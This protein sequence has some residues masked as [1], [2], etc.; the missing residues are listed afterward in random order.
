M[1][2]PRQINLI[3]KRRDA[4]RQ[5]LD[6]EAPY[7]T[8]DQRHL[9]AHTPEQA[10]WQY[11]YQAALADI[12]RLVLQT[13]SESA[14]SSEDISSPTRAVAPDVRGSPED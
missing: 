1:L 14:R 13:T 11:G 7:V 12:L 4:I 9:D 2:E 10:Y 5:W 3:E 8:C 6:D